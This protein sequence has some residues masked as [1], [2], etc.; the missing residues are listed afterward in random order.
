[1]I[2]T[3][4]RTS[5]AEGALLRAMFEA[6]KHVFVDLLKWDVPVLGGTWEIDQF[7]NQDATYIILA[8]PAGRH[9]GSTRLL[10][11]DRPHILDTL[12]AGL[13]EGHVPAGADIYEITRFCLDRRLNATDRRQVRN[14]LVTAIAE[15]ALA[16]GIRRYTGVAEMT[17]FQQILAFGW[18]C[19]PLGLP[20][21]CDGRM[22]AG[23]SIEI[24]G[25]TPRLLEEAGIYARC[26]SYA[27][28]AEAA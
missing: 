8:D 19:L 16:T 1:M 18:R 20:R 26:D 14:Q 6:R 17:W 7:D 5:D 3:I 11:T 23:L 28:P 12:F 25:D 10:R 22:L 15:H 21:I 13:C 27:L 24:D 4:D 9:L 2:R